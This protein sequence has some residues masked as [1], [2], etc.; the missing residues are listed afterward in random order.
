MSTLP[1]PSTDPTATAPR[2]RILPLAAVAGPIL[3]TVAWIVLGF[4]STGYTLFDHTYTH[5]SPVSQPVSGLGI[6]T[7]A[8]WMNTA[9]VLSGTLLIIGVLGVFR[10]IPDRT[11]S[12]RAWSI[13][14]LSA[15]GVGMIIDGVFT[16]RFVIP[17][18]LGFLLA[19]G[20]PVIGFPLAGSYLRHHPQWRA[21]GAWLQLAGPLTLLLIVA[22]FATFTPT[23]DGAEHGIAGLIERVLATEV[24]LSF[25]V[26]GIH[27]ATQRPRAMTAAAAT[28]D[29]R[30]RMRNRPR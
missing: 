10:A 28:P 17:H 16:L 23:A 14:L 25:A 21:I 3:F 6:G 22:F 18:T 2:Q 12:K 5:Y 30:Y 19:A 7:T 26:L 4:L 1:Q 13:A 11:S 9:F 27:A 24:L 20:V 29:R 8:P 15:A